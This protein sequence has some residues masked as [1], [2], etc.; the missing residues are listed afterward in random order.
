MYKY[1]HYR[2]DRYHLTHEFTLAN[3]INFAVV[4]GIEN[5]IVLFAICI[6]SLMNAFSY[7]ESGITRLSG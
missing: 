5:T 3:Q 1:I 2:Y 4:E 6:L 7:L